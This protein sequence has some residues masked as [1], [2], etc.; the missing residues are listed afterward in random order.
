M[1]KFKFKSLKTKI[2]LSLLPSILASFLVLSLISYFNSKSIIEKQINSTMD[3]HMQQIIGSIQLQLNKHSRI[4]ESLGRTIENS[5]NVVTK[6]ECEGLLKK[7]IALN[8][9]TFGMGIWFE[10]Y[11]YKKDIKYFAP[12]AYREEGK[13][14]YTD[15]YSS[16]EFDYP[17]YDWYK[18]GVNTDK[19]VVWSQAYEDAVT[20]VPMVTAT[21]PFYDEQKNFRGVVTGDI[22]LA[23]LV[24]MVKNIKVGKTGK[25]FLL[26]KDG[27]YL[28][29]RDTEK[30]MKV[31]IAEDSNKSLASLSKQLT[32][33][34]K[35][36]AEFKD[37]NGE[38]IIQYDI[39]PETN[40]VLA[41]AIPKKELNA[42]LHN[43]IKILLILTLIV[44][45][46]IVTTIILFSNGMIKDIN[47]VNDFSKAMSQ[48]DFTKIIEVN[49]EDEIGSMIRNLSTMT[50]NLKSMFIKIQ[51]SIEKVAASSEEL[52]ASSEQTLSASENIAISMQE[53]A[54]GSEKQVIISQES[55]ET[56]YEMNTGMEQITESVQL[57]VDSS[58]KASEVA[59]EGSE[60]VNKVI[61]QMRD[62]NNKVTDSSQAV[63]VLGKKSD[64]IEEIVS[65]I[66]SIAEQTNLLALNA[67]IEA[68]RAG[69]HGKGFAV[70]AEEVRK[71]A[72]QSGGA[73]G[74]ISKLIREIQNEIRQA[75]TS[76][77]EGADSVKDGMVMVDNAG[78]SFDKIKN[79]VDDVSKQMFQVSSVVEEIYAGTENMVKSIESILEISKDTSGNTQNVAASAEEQSSLMVEV[80]NSA[81]TLTDMAI[82]LEREISKF[83]IN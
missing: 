82:E 51:D 74:Q 47:K 75:V 35:G 5:A 77:N 24:N 43:L 18:N 63:N 65:L 60:A 26:E 67:A 13:I 53:V 19:S 15:E 72:E 76:M 28:S 80:S 78:E 52:T 48:G 11:K 57:V 45:A 46:V 64:K 71:L 38:N 73:A 83:K 81:K 10:P 79:A 12:Y 3:L 36:K 69:E 23:S 44:T 7:Y 56:V 66:S 2:I 50:N 8:D 55:A 6:E 25:A 4:T 30:N 31:N 33:G 68:A 59:R 70:V 61:N 17:H 40:W 54:E 37:E 16:E 27:L 9:N 20:K 62:I 42:P 32:S 21:V 1:K 22:D 39:I 29:D 58:E 14:I 49:S 41:L 34:Q